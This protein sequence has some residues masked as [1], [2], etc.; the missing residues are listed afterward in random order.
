MEAQ[1]V[2]AQPVDAQ[3]VDAQAVDATQLR[4]QLAAQQAQLDA[5]QRQLQLQQRTLGAMQ[6]QLQQQLADAEPAAPTA[7]R[8]KE[9]H[10]DHSWQG[11]FAVEAINTRFAIG[12]FA[13][14]DVIYDTAAMSTPCQFVTAAIATDG[15]SPASGSDG[16]TSFCVNPSRF[17]VESR[18]YFGER[19]LQ[20]YFALDLFGDE[21]TPVPRIREAYGKLHNALWGIHVLVGQTWS[22]FGNTAAWPDIVDFEGPNSSVARRQPMVQF[23]RD[24]GLGFA[25]SLAAESPFTRNIEAADS[26]GRWPDGVIALEWSHGAGHLNLASI[27]RDLRASADG[28]PVQSATGWGVSGSGQLV[29]PWLLGKDNF[30]FQATYGQGMGSYFDDFGPDAVF[31]PVDN[32]LRTV[33]VLAAYVAIEHYW[34]SWLSSTATY[35]GL[36]VDNLDI[37]PTDA[38][39]NTRYFSVN[40]IWRPYQPLMFGFEYLRGAR[41]D[42]DQNNGTNNRFQLASKFT[43]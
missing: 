27:V 16:R 13:E 34:A 2:E 1:P 9:P 12:G 7:T 26:L 11:S 18:T 40:I 36:R 37:E 8:A 38:L 22:T 29:F 35:G 33:P 42:K 25:L 3:P 21:P 10:D 28:G 39:H 23:S 30:V 41:T 20:T 17:W 43:F 31:D 4:Q 24:L 6:Q 19:E 14:L 15:G 5:Q 32:S